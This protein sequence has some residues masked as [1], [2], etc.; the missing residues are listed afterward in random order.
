M[1]A[2]SGWLTNDLGARILS[3]PS[4]GRTEPP[5]LGATGRLNYGALE[6]RAARQIASELPRVR[7]NARLNTRMLG[8]PAQVCP[9]PGCATQGT[10]PLSTQR[11]RL[12]SPAPTLDL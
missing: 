12:A 1:R 4:L 5:A 11:P 8:S 7:L 3:G 6:L 10:H 2:P 9:G